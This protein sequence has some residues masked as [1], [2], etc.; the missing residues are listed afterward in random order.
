[1]NLRKQRGVSLSGA[2]MVMVVLALVGLVVAKMAPAYIDYFAIKKVFAAI[3]SDGELKR[4]DSGA[5]RLSYSKRARIDNI[6]SIEPGDLQISKAPDGSAVIS[7]E[8]S[9]RTPLVAN[10]SLIIDFAVS[11]ANLN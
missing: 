9:V 11:T 8:Y 2:V 10:V 7:V 1:M 4:L 6:K 5:L 3:G